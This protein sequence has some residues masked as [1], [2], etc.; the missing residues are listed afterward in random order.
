MKKYFVV[1]YFLAASSIAAIAAAPA[2]AQDADRHSTPPFRVTPYAGYMVFGK[3]LEGPLGVGLTNESAP[4]YGAELGIHLTDNIALVGN[5]GYAK[6][7]WQVSAPIVGGF[8][9]GDASVLMYDA[10]LQL[11][12][13]LGGRFGG[14]LTPVV[15]LGVGA[16]RHSADNLPVTLKSTNLALNAG[17][18]F[19]YQLS[20][21][22]GMRVMAKDYMSKLDFGQAVGLDGVE[23]L[24]GKRA[25]NVALSVGV[26]VGF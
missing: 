18:G 26:S 8:S 25:H 2:A 19:D 10:G 6:S 24:Q 13:P 20:R 3:Y 11:R 23:F 17:L 15:Q 5:V 16:M 4:V 12:A 9:F 14:Q 22:L 21:N 7:S 1:G